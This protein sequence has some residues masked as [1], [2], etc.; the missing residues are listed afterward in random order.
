MSRKARDLLESGGVE[1]QIFARVFR[2]R[3]SG[4]GAAHYRV[5]YNQGW[6]TCTCPAGQSGRE[7]CYHR[8]AVRMVIEGG[9]V[10]GQ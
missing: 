7:S 1:E 9:T 4:Q 5:V 2:V 6:Y 10:G 3:G 8:D